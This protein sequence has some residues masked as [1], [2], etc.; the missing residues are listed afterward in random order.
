MLSLF[1]FLEFDDE[2]SFVMTTKKID[3]KAGNVNG[4]KVDYRQN[5]LDIY[6]GTRSI[7]D[8]FKIYLDIMRELEKHKANPGHN[9]IEASKKLTGIEQKRTGQSRTVRMAVKELLRNQGIPF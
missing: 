1:Y 4:V 8:Q 6:E 5:L 9:Y 2:Y 3:I 7:T